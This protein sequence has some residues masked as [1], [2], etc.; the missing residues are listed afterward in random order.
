[1]PTLSC[2]YSTSSSFLIREN[3]KYTL[4]LSRTI[5]YFFS[6]VILEIWSRKGSGL[7]YKWV[8]LP[9]VGQFSYSLRTFIFL[10]FAWNHSYKLEYFFW[11]ISYLLVIS[12]WSL[13]IK[14]F[15]SSRETFNA[16]SS[17]SFY[18]RILKAFFF[19]FSNLI[20]SYKS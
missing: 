9:N 7:T 1:M 12:F 15:L 19:D 4:T 20:Y 10:W 13:F 3:D 8:I 16:F 14:D 2:N 11:M 5:T 6:W 17:S 18:S